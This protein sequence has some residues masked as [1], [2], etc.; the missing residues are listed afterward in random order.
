MRRLSPLLPLTA[1][2]LAGLAGAQSAPSLPAPTGVTWTLTGLT[3][4]GRLIAPE[5]GAARPTLRLDG[6]V[7]AGTTGCNVYRAPY[8]LRGDVLRFG[9]LGTTRRACPGGAG[10]LEARFV[11]LL[12]GVT[13]YRL[14]G[15]VLTL[16]AGQDDR[17]VFSS[18]GVVGQSGGTSS[19]AR[20][21]ASVNLDGNWTLTGGTA[22]RPLAGNAPS[23]TLTQGRVSGSG[24]C[25]RLS[26]SVRASGDALTF[27]PLAVTRMAC[28]PAVNAQ[29]QTFLTVLGTPGLRVNVQGLGLTLTV[30]SGPLAGQ[31]LVFRRAGLTGGAALRDPTPPAAP[32]PT[33]RDGLYRLTGVNGQP[34]PHTPQPVTLSLEGARL[35]GNDGC[36]SFGG[37]YRLVGGRLSLT[38]PLVGTLRACP[39]PEAVTGLQALLRA[40][41]TLTVTA[42]GLT[43]QAG[44]QTLTFTR[45]GR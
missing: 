43:L 33:A 30:P 16:F 20:P 25:N 32:A 15:P 23:L 21:E 41:P 18:G 40:R 42:G 14:S 36:N 37:E 38:G 2:A 39:E 10:A 34:V 27:G 13:R 9:S 31:T 24:G 12:E 11:N 3:D 29:E 19:S 26:G 8:A 17:L 44:G 28:A 6:R 35:G 7:A 1:L 45:T 22:L 4:G 5:A